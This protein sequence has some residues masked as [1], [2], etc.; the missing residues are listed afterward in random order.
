ML[1]AYDFNY[2]TH[3]SS[4]VPKA[5]SSFKHNDQVIKTARPDKY[6]NKNFQQ[7]TLRF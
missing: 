5:Y 7:Q 3:N 1:L 4:L 6:T 2:K